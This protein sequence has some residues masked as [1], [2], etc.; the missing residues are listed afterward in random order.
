MQIRKI[1]NNQAMCPI[2]LKINILKCNETLEIFLSPHVCKCGMQ[3][4]LLGPEYR[5]AEQGDEK[6]QDDYS[7]ITTYQY[8]TIFFYEITQIKQLLKDTVES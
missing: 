5:K 7:S 3:V 6:K 8:N 1:K 4:V 2:P